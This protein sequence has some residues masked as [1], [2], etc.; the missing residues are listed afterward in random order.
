MVTVTSLIQ[1]PVTHNP[2]STS[3]FYKRLGFEEITNG[4]DQYFTDGLAVIAVNPDRKARTAVRLFGSNWESCLDKLREVVEVHEDSGTYI[5][6]DPSGV[7]V[8][9]EPENEF[10]VAGQPISSLGKFAGLSIETTEFSRCLQF[11]QALGY[12]ASCGDPAHGWVGLEKKGSV[13][14]SI[15][16]FG[17]C[18]HL[19]F[20]PGLTYFNSG[21]NL[22]NIAHIRE[23][24]IEITEEISCFNPD[25]VVDNVVIRD[26]GGT[27]FF[28]FN[29]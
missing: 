24:G 8:H 1:T 6:S 3:D 5:C 2:D 21:R 25:S 15:M 4:D 22:E 11:W 14:I 18:P 7:R 19:F 23:A 12:E 26:P 20:S 16:K 27:S 29:D 10:E 9:L 17:A 28:V 13:G